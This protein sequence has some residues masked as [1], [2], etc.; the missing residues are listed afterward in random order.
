MFMQIGRWTRA[1][2]ADDALQTLMHE[3]MVVQWIGFLVESWRP[4][5]NPGERQA[6][7]PGPA[8]R[9]WPESSTP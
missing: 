2:R 3:L 7:A 1:I 8:G 9:A 6:S 5:R 4:Y